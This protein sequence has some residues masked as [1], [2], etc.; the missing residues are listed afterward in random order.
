LRDE[1]LEVEGREMGDRT[2]RLKEAKETRHLVSF[3]GGVQSTALFLLIKDSPE[4]VIK[5]MGTLP[6]AFF[7]ADT[8]AEPSEVYDHISLIAGMV[9]KRPL[10]ICKK[11]GPTL[12]KVILGKIGSRSL[13]IPAFTKDK[14]GKIGMLRRQCTREYKIAPLQNAMRSYIGIE[15]RKHL[16]AKSIAS[17]IGISTDESGRVKDSGCKGIINLYPLLEMGISRDDCRDIIRS[18]GI[19][20]VKSRCYFC[21]YI[22]DWEQFSKDHSS[23]FQKAVVLDK[24]IRNSTSAGV[25]QPA[26][27][28]RDCQPLE[29]LGIGPAMTPDPYE[30]WMF[31]EDCEGICG[32]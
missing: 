17:W 28:R 22:G 2:R 9:D 5:A 20:P 7:F 15:P 32:I 13:P 26:Y 14:D 4:L 16:P 8:G 30:D 12:E 19:S 10:I 24:S 27:L 25:V 21:P 6:E 29:D 3:G 11:P 1:N 23:A 31:E 18:A